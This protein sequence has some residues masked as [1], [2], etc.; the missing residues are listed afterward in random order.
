M[1]SDTPKQVPCRI[2][3]S[4][5]LCTVVMDPIYFT[6]AILSELGLQSLTSFPTILL[7]QM[8][9]AGTRLISKFL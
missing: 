9:F 3:F 1:Y 8:R 5:G 6:T 7:R 4:T 2:K